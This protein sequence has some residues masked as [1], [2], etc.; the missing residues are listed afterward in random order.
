MVDTL[1]LELLDTST[2][3]YILKTV[4][5]ALLSIN[6]CTFL[7]FYDYLQKKPK[8]NKKRQNFILR[9]SHY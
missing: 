8:Q 1:L 9:K 5:V 6:L 2:G 7:I 4:R 3:F